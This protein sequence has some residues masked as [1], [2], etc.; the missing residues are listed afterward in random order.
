MMA[1]LWWPGEPKTSKTR[2]P[3]SK[4]TVWAGQMEASKPKK[5]HDGIEVPGDHCGVGAVGELGVARDVIA[6][7]M[8][9]RDD[10]FVVAARVPRQPRGDQVVH[11]AAQGELLRI[12][13]GPGVEQQSPLVAEQ[14][15]KEWCF[16]VGGLALPQDHGVLVVMVD[17]NRGNR[18]VGA[19]ARAVL[20][21]DVERAGG[22]RRDPRSR[23]S[24]GSTVDDGV[25]ELASDDR[26]ALG[27][28]TDPADRDLPPTLTP[29]RTR[30]RLLHV[31]VLRELQQMK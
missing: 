7:S 13:R 27:A 5:V 26:V 9:V 25:L 8:R 21:D 12:L 20:P 15:K 1:A 10:E 19:A 3:R 30:V 14:Q 22:R 4:E 16:V 18:A 24:P 23:E 6:V 31:A 17:L 2:P 29:I 11:G 28:E